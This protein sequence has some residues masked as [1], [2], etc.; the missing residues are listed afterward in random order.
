LFFCL[1]SDSLGHFRLTAV[2][3]TFAASLPPSSRVQLPLP[4]VHFLRI[5]PLTCS[6]SSP[7][8]CFCFRSLLFFSSA[9]FPFSPE[10]AIQ[11]VCLV[12][13]RLLSFYDFN[14]YIFVHLFFFSILSTVLVFFV[15]SGYFS[16]VT[17]FGL[18]LIRGQSFL[19]ITG[20]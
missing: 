9:L 8:T 5:P 6:H 1:I 7:L 4:V 15:L 11:I 16:A 19:S 14:S 18:P 10:I 17:N 3:C 20:S 13:D 2:I 12:N